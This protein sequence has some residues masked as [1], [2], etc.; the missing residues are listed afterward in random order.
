MVVRF[1]SWDFSVSVLHVKDYVCAGINAIKGENT[2]YK[3]F[4]SFWT[5]LQRSTQ[6]NPKL[7]K[8][9]T[10]MT[11]PVIRKIN[12]YFRNAT[13]TAAGE[14]KTKIGVLTVTRRTP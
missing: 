3:I 5:I 10:K 12:F 6:Y 1:Q 4:I 9:V 8:Q 11:E 14:E 7:W 2:D 13:L